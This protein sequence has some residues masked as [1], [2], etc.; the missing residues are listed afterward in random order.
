MMTSYVKRFR[1]LEEDIHKCQILKYA[2]YNCAGRYT[3]YRIFRGA[4]I[5]V[6]VRVMISNARPFLLC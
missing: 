1:Q 3:Y 2:W 5:L 6:F 4:V